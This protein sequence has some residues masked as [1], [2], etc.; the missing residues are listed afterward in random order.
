MN[1]K[2][3]ELKSILKTLTP[4]R[5]IDNEGMTL[6]HLSARYDNLEMI[7]F[8]LVSG[9]DLNAKN[10]SEATP[11][12]LAILHNNFAAARLLLDA[13]ADALTTDCDGKNTLQLLT[14]KKRVPTD[15]VEY[16]FVKLTSKGVDAEDKADILTRAGCSL[17][18][19]VLYVKDAGIIQALLRRKCWISHHESSVALKHVVNSVDLQNLRVLVHHGPGAAKRKKD[20]FKCFYRKLVSGCSKLAL[21]RSV[22]ADLINWYVDEALLQFLQNVFEKKP[23]EVVQLFVQCSIDVRVTNVSGQNLLAHLFG[24]PNRGVIKLLRNRQF[25]VNTRGRGGMSALHVAVMN[26]LEGNVKYLLGMG[27]D[28]NVKDDR[29]RTPLLCSNAW[30]SQPIAE[31]LLLERES[32]AEQAQQAT[33]NECIAELLLR[34]GADLQVVDDSERTVIEVFYYLSS[35]EPIL[36]RLAI[37]ECQGAQIQRL[38]RERIDAK[39]GYRDFYDNCLL[40]VQALRKYKI[41]RGVTLLDA[42]TRRADKIDVRSRRTIDAMLDYCDK[43]HFHRVYSEPLK[44]KLEKALKIYEAR[45]RAAVVIAESTDMLIDPNHLATE[46]IVSFLTDEDLAVFQ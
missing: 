26:G 35:M 42:F 17:V 29:G 46:M 32:D 43:F 40:Q 21:V 12:F 45:C 15:F 2:N 39:E 34:Y 4:S 3:D 30:L 6:L 44:L 10:S 38:I 33:Q 19:V 37:A 5:I 9:C 41:N 13:E 16:F 8:S 7:K 28:P 31:H 14:E 36:A 1:H 23:K 11:L 27:A 25:D 20:F 18:Y 24:N 22:V